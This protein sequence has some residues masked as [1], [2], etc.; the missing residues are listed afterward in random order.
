M[1]R[2]LWVGGMVLAMNVYG[3]DNPFDLAKNMQKIEAEDTMLLDTLEDEIQSTNK[4]DIKSDDFVVS[5]PQIRPDKDQKNKEVDIDIKSSDIVAETTKP[6]VEP[7]KEIKPATADNLTVPSKPKED[8][9]STEV[10]TNDTPISNTKVVV[11]EKQ[12]KSIQKVS[13]QDNTNI[14][15]TEV[16]KEDKVEPKAEPVEKPKEV[17]RVVKVTKNNP[18]QISSVADI[19]LTK[20]KEEMAL[21]V[22]KELEEA[23]KDVDRED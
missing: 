4:D 6:K 17:K 13:K 9:V 2:Y 14:R 21:K 5:K 7:K 22:Q 23:I 12:E 10:K 1:K 11:K 3:A 8:V 15:N 20:E 18:N 19:N 16:T